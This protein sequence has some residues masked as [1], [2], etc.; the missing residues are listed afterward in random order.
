MSI[1]SDFLTPPA[2]SGLPWVL[3]LALLGSAHAQVPALPALP[4][5]E[6]ER[7]QPALPADAPVLSLAELVRTVLQHNPGLQAAE[8]SRQAASAAIQSAGALPNP[9]IEWGTGQQR[10]RVPS[11]QP[12]TTSSWGVAQFIENPGVRRARLAAARQLERGSV[13]QFQQQRGELVAQVRL[14]AFEWLL[15]Q[16]EAQAAADALALLTQI[17]E[18]VKLRVETGEAARYE[19]IK[20]DAEIVSARQRLQT[21]SL[22]TEQATLGLNRLAAGALPARWTLNASLSDPTELDAMEEYRRQALTHNPELRV[23]ATEVA[24]REARRKEAQASRWP[25]VELR[26]SQVRDPEVRQNMLSASVQIPL[27][28]RRE[29]PIVEAEAELARART[30]LDGRKAELEQQIKLAWKEVELARVK[31]HALSTGAI[32]EAEAALR[33]AQAAYRFGERGILDVLDAQRLLRSVR[34]DLLDA[35]F[36]AQAAKVELE[37]LAGRFTDPDSPAATLIEE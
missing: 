35:R 9:S 25:G 26:Y 21:A 14:K 22:Q 10:A 23:L 17:R 31:V 24:R 28:D 29:G 33:V 19:I 2:R 12:G 30:L 5:G 3:S 15:R 11:V 7:P 6:A 32:R 13:E 4:P 20:A 18:R 37:Y 16:E 1:L 8:R 34:A 27:L 36:Q